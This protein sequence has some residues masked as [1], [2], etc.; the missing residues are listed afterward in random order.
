MN[1]KFL[2]PIIVTVMFASVQAQTVSP[3]VLAPSGAWFSNGTF[4]LSSTIGETT[5]VQTFSDATNILTQGFQQPLEVT[6]DII[7]VLPNINQV[8]VYPNPSNGNFVV[9][10]QFESAG[11]IVFR[12]FDIIGKTIDKTEIGFDQ[13]VTLHNFNLNPLADGIYFMEAV[14]TFSDGSTQRNVIK[15]NIAN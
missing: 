15:L 5:L 3:N 10:F 13:G 8:H 6:T 11:T 7:D 1:K 12:V 14:A 2:L 4:S 9:S